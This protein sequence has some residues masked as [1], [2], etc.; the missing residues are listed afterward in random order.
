[1]AIKH[2]P[3]LP[4]H[5]QPMKKQLLFLLL[6]LPLAALAEYNG[7]HIEFQLHMQN[8]NEVTGYKF[9]AHREN[10]EE[11][12]TQ[13]ELQPILLLRNH[14]SEEPGAYGYYQHRLHYDFPET[15]VYELI[16][17]VAIDLIQFKSLSITSM[18]V[19]S[20]ATQMADSH[21]LEIQHW[22]NTEPIWS[23]D[24]SANLCTS[25][26]FIHLAGEVPS[27]EME[28][29]KSI[30]AQV[31]MEFNAKVK[32]FEHLI[33]SGEEYN[34]LIKPIYDKRKNALKSILAEFNQ[35]KT[36]TIDTC[37]C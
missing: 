15:T 21:Q 5:H 26:I 6:F 8:G 36:V 23:Y 30:L 29:M 35:L 2:E 33:S 14:F 24:E 37:T 13:L 22:M 31:E 4:L 12:K 16:D 25:A 34:E 27:V 10:T 18:I 11:Y 1:M 9:I 19:S 7:V 28:K 32:K 3:I 20:Y 17:P